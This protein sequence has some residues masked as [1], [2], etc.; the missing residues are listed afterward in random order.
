MFK[1]EMERQLMHQDPFASNK[2]IK[3]DDHV[4]KNNE[5]QYV[6][7]MSS[8][9]HTYGNVLAYI[10]KWV[11]DL[12]PENLF[13]TIHVNSKIAHRQLRSTSHEFIKKS[14]PMIIFRPRVADSSEERFLKGTMLT[15]RQ[16]DIYSTWGGTSLQPFMSMPEKKLAVKYQLNRSILFIDVI[17]I[18][19]TMM[20]QLDFRHYLENAVRINQP[21]M[22]TTYLESY[23]PQEML[24]LI[25]QLI[26]IPLYDDFG[27]TKDFLSYMSGNSVYPV[28]YKLQG[29]SGTREFYR[30]Y[31]ANIDTVISDISTD[32]GE[33][34]GHVLSNYQLSFTIR[35]EFNSTGLYYLFSNKIPKIDM[36]VTYP[37]NTTIIPIFTDI[38]LKEDLNLRDGWRLYNRASC[39]LDGPG[40]IINIKE[41]MNQSIMKVIDYH[42]ANGLPLIDVIDIKI[43]K[44]GELISP[45]KDYVINWDTLD[46]TFPTGSEYYTYTILVCANIDYINELIKTL[47]NLA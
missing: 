30:Y 34:N 14:K 45:I 33:K 19:S 1:Y 9:S 38:K 25:S 13:K 6:A 20:Q 43:R 35:V 8:M 47:H 27:S 41:L 2:M 10:Q 22:L 12:F 17:A 4:T 39:R 11:L 21:F 37:E 7:L 31:P 46:I 24:Y 32:D 23:I 44:Q 26:D 42:K 29:S 3:L 16:A 28:T 40:D 5:N 18:F 15:E 36:P